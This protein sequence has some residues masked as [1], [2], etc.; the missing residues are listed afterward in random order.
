MCRQSVVLLR[1]HLG[2]GMVGSSSTS[3]EQTPVPPGGG[4]AERLREFLAARGESAPADAVE[5]ENERDQ[6]LG[7]P[8]P[9][10]G[11]PQDQTGR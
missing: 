9:D 1:H 11:E 5:S 7:D 2:V 10:V 4:A 3:D 6:K 8:P